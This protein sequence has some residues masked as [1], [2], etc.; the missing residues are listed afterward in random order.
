M[1]AGLAAREQVTTKQLEAVRKTI[2]EQW[3]REH[4]KVKAR[5]AKEQESGIKRKQQAQS[6]TASQGTKGGAKGQSKSQGQE[7]GH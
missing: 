5:G 6:R 4:G 3:E 1:R 7:H 2:R